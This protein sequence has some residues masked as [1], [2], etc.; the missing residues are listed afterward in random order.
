[1]KSLSFCFFVPL[2]VIL[3]ICEVEWNK[4]NVSLVYRAVIPFSMYRSNAFPVKNN[5]VHAR[6]IDMSLLSFPTSNHTDMLNQLVFYQFLQLICRRRYNRKLILVH[7]KLAVRKQFVILLFIFVT[8][9]ILNDYQ[10]IK[11]PSCTVTFLEES[12]TSCTASSLRSFLQKCSIFLSFVQSDF[13]GV[14]CRFRQL[15]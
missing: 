14:E 5:V 13:H 11:K 1:M 7:A 4:K 10:S 15:H 3:F 12:P 9:V 2:L 6:P 8:R